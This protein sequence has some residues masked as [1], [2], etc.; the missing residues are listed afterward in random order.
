MENIQ[1]LNTPELLHLLRHHNEQYA[2]L[3]V[4]GSKEEFDTCRETITCIQHEL[5]LRKQS[6]EN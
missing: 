6:E 4:R 2:E 3:M 1:S 5:N